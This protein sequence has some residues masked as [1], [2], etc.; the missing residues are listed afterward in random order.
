MMAEINRALHHEG[1]SSEE[2]NYECDR[3]LHQAVPLKVKKPYYHRRVVGEL[4]ED[5]DDAIEMLREKTVRASGKRYTRGLARIRLRSE[6]KSVRTV[7][8]GLPKALYH[9]RYLQGLNPN[10]L[11]HVKP[12]EDQIPHFAQFED[13]VESDSMEE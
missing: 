13:G 11:A 8:H 7:K 2:S 5:V 12:T 1:Q 10:A 4:M 3:L 6:E 9:R